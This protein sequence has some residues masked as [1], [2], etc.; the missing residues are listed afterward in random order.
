MMVHA[1]KATA[2]LGARQWLE[3]YADTH[4]EMSP[5]DGKAYL[6]AGRKAFYYAHYKKDTME[7]HGVADAETADARAYSLALRRSK[8]RRVAGTQTGGSWEGR[9]PCPSI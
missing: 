4:T 5:T 1:N 2:Y 9:G 7:R 3:W 6:P 8:R